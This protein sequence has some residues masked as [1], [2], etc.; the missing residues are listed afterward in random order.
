MK[1]AT[2]NRWSSVHSWSSLVCTAFLLM[3]CITGLPLIFHH[4]IE[5]ALD[6]A[7]WS[8]A[9][10]G[11]PL[12]SLDSVL[13][14][15]LDGRPGE[16]PL[17]MS[18]DVDRPVVN[19][20]TGPAPD[21]V[22]ADMHFASFDRTS[23]ALVPPR[24]DGIMEFLLQ[25]H[26]DL[27]LGLPGMLFLGAMGVLFTV[28]LISGVVLY[29]PFMRKQEFGV[30]RRGRSSR[31]RWLDWHD[32]AGIVVLAWALVVGLTGV[33]NTLADPIF[34]TWKREQL[35][36]LVSANDAVGVP[37]A[38]LTSLD[39]AVAR[40][41][42]AA[43]EKELQFIAFPGGAFSTAGHLALF[44]RGDAP[45]TEHLTTP[46]LIDARSGVLVDLREMPWYV[47]GLSLSKP[48]HFGDYGGLP[49][50]VLWALLD[51]FAIVV[52]WSGLVLWWRRRRGSGHR[53]LSVP[54]RTERGRVA[55][56]PAR[57]M[58]RSTWS[59]PATLAVAVLVGLVV[60]LISDGAADR[61]GW[62]LLALAPGAIALGWWR[63]ERS[64]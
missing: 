18:F 29:A 45:L 50:K 31:L 56:G 3:L 41:R 19:V 63:R 35:A 14:R 30:L 12:R 15:A 57:A 54:V 61:L 10:P 34:E 62:V 58:L 44:L 27:F 53:A 38:E 47:K 8:P 17:F 11:G 42:A 5:D 28:A 7:A 55:R 51:L 2:L 46:A 26:I 4:E 23:R 37:P 9:N 32:L 13:D 43:P 1:R 24:E 6:P 48:L 36:D 33:I 20:T 59:I 52:L 40:A 16:V 21:A 49:L 60:A 22:E 25:L 64:A 39:A